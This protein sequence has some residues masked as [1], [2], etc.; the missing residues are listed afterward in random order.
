MHNGNI[1]VLRGAS[2]YRGY[3][4]LEG[5]QEQDEV[6]ILYLTEDNTYVILIDQVK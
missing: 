4:S 6:F 5:C 1:R 2:G 3:L